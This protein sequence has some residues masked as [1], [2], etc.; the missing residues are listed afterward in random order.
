MNNDAGWCGS[1]G[2]WITPG[3]L[4]AARR[5]DG[6][7]RRPARARFDARAAAAEG[8]G[9]TS[10]ATSR[11]SPFPRRPS[12]YVIPHLARQVGR[13][14][15]RRFRCARTF[16]ALPADAV[17]PRDRIVNLT[18]QARRRTA[19]LT[20]DVPAGN[21]T[22]L[23]LGH[24]T[25]GKDNHPAPVDGRGLECDKLSKEAAEA[26]FDGLMGKLIADNQAAGR[27]E[28]TLVS[29]H[30]DSWEVGS[31][32]WT[33]KFREEFQRLRGYD[34]LPFLPVMSGRVVDSLEVSERFLWDVRMTVND[35]LLENYAGHFRDAG[36]PARAAALHRGLRRRAGR[37]HGLRRPG[38]RADGRVLVLAPYSARPTVVHGDG[39]G[40]ARLW[41]A[42]PGR[43][44]LHRHRR[45]E[46]AGAS[47]QHQ[48]PGRLGV[49]RGHQ[50]LRLPSLRPPAVDRPD[51]ARHVHGA[52]GPAL[53]AHADLV[54]A[55]AGLA[56]VPGPLP[57]PAAARALRGRPLLPRAGDVAAAL[58]VAGEIR[59]TTGPA[60]TST[61]ARRKWCS[62][63]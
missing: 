61:A 5:V 23:R 19:G 55:V 57:V 31:Q 24:T 25:T 43:R 62:P 15:R 39:L 1:G 47:R 11:C 41:Q 50:P 28:S 53:R 63:A 8:R 49:L 18:A 27:R 20:W 9:R 45:R 29:T 38:R 35:L 6:D 40:G 26:M 34:P 32:N 44:G 3:A 54:G 7:E 17:V 2:P 12:N 33:P 60:T 22:I 46:V 10:T 4:H 51:R 21:W 16:P 42:D 36:A 14:A 13:R 37:R 58:Q 59:A 30:I 56:R 52:V 48:G